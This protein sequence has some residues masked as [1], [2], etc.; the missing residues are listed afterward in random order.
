MPRSDPKPA[1]RLID[2]SRRLSRETVPYVYQKFGDDK[3]FYSFDIP[4]DHTER[5]EGYLKGPVD[6]SETA[7]KIL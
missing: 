5:A 2:D 3:F 7:G 4:S 6:L 1:L